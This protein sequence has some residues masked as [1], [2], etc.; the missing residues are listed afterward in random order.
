MKT[1]TTVVRAAAVGGAAVL[2]ATAGPAG[3]AH[4]AE[5][6]LPASASAAGSASSPS[7]AAGS[8]DSASAVFRAKDTRSRDVITCK[9]SAHRPHYS[10]HADA[11]NKH[12]VNTTADITCSKKVSKLDVRVGL[13]KNGTI[14]KR[15]SVKSASG[16]KYV[17]QNAARRCI[18]KQRYAGLAKG[19]V[20]FPPGYSPRTKSVSDQSA[21]VVIRACKKK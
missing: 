9:L 4:P 14:Y 11:K 20:T 1:A 6:S 17:R 10:H 8:G 15:S 21:S 12:R 7:S 5:R 18:K 16:K 3:A 19:V 2:I 13:Y